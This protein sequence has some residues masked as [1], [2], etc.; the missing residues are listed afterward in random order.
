MQYP[1][2]K[3]KIK[4]IKNKNPKIKKEIKEVKINIPESNKVIKSS[5]LVSDPYLHH[6]QILDSIE[7]IK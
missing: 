1:E 2:A 6:K 5:Y 4:E 3:K 7:R